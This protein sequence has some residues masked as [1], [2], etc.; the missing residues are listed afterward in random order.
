MEKYKSYKLF[1]RLKGISASNAKSL[2][3]FYEIIVK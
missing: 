2:F 1:C 3:E